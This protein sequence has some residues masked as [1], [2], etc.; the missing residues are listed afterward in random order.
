[1]ACLG[2]LP[3][4]CA[5]IALHNNNNNIEVIHINH[6]KR[7]QVSA[8]HFVLVSNV[9]VDTATRAGDLSY[10][11]SLEEFHFASQTLQPTAIANPSPQ[12]STPLAECKLRISSISTKQLSTGGRSEQKHRLPIGSLCVYR[13]V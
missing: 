3:A 11:Q 8:K 1:M 10:S 2:L 9:A 7:G 4:C 12:K 13:P 5:P 6:P